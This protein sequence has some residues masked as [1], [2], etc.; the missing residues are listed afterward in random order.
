MLLD[1]ETIAQNDKVLL[2]WFVGYAMTKLE[3]FRRFDIVAGALS[4]DE[5]HQEIKDEY[6]N[7]WS[8]IEIVT[9]EDFYRKYRVPD[10]DVLNKEEEQRVKIMKGR[11]AEE[12]AADAANAMTKDAAGAAK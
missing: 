5:R 1:K 12:D 2:E 6:Q 3:H 10:W 4:G 11:W 7:K 8:H 9:A